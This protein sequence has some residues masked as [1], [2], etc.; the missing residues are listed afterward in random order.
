MKRRLAYLDV[1]RIISVLLVMWGHFVMVAGGA[2]AIP[3]II[4]PDVTLLP[5]I[6]QT[7]WSAYLFEVFLIEKFS[8]Q[9]AILGVSIFFLITGYLMPVMCERYT[10]KE[11]LINRFFR[12]FPTLVAAVAMLGFFLYFTQGI[13]FNAV[14]YIASITL[15]YPWFGIVP[16]AGVL[17]TLVIEVIFYLIAFLVGV[18]TLRR[19]VF[20][21]AILLLTVFL[22]AAYREHY[23]LW[24][25]GYQARFLL[26]ISIGSSIYLAEKEVSALAKIITLLPSVVLSY[27]GF[28]LFKLGKVDASTYENLGTHLLSTAIFLGFYH[29]GPLLLTRLPRIV[30]ALSDLVY[31]FYLVHAAIGLVAMALVR[32]HL[33]QPYLMLLSAVLASLIV[34]WVLHQLVEKPA[35]NLGRRFTRSNPTA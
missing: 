24:L 18:F 34:S 21:Q 30:D 32:E 7:Q 26:F 17:W 10:R 31:P 35:I 25:A 23:Y 8:T 3:G 33:H 5:L 19:L 6:D 12:I 13:T 28:Q 4:N 16:I 14:S 29:L 1:L 9:S 11:F 15:T 2:Q 20:I 27:I 22:G